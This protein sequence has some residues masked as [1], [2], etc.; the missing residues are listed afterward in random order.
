MSAI[1]KIMSYTG[2]IAIVDTVKDLFINTRKSLL[3]QP[4]D[5]MYIHL[6]S[7]KQPKKIPNYIS[8]WPPFTLLKK[9]KSTTPKMIFG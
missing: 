4:H 1:L 3:P 2:A 6:L 8:L 5:I 9:S 7:K